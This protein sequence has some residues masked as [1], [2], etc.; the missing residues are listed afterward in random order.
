MDHKPL[1]VDDDPGLLPIIAIVVVLAAVLA[2][3]LW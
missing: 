3:V 1:R 2:F